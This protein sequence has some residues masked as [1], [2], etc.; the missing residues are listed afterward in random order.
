MTQASPKPYSRRPTKVWAAARADYEAGVSMRVIAERH[1]LNVRTVARH[2][3]AEGWQ[4][5]HVPAAELYDIHAAGRMHDPS[6]VQE[7]IAVD[8]LGRRDET[9]LLLCPDAHGLARFAFRRAAECAAMRGPNEALV[10]LRLAE[11]TARLRR[12]VDVDVRPMSEADYRRITALAREE[13][14]AEIDAIMAAP[15]EDLPGGSIGEL[16]EMSQTVP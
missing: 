4:A 7:S 13:T 12:N 16:S 9:A 8:Q 6:A 11:A 15:P 14:A 1:Q 3:H 10:W 2:V 5:R